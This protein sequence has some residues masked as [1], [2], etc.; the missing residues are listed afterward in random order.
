VEA[1]FYGLLDR[2]MPYYEQEMIGVALLKRACD[3]GRNLQS[4]TFNST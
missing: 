4:S 2:V 1:D 3:A